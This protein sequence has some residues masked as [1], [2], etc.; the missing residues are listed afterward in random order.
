MVPP[1]PPF[2]SDQKRHRGGDEEREGERKMREVMV[3]VEGSG[4]C[5][6]VGQ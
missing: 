3:T 5:R 6:R 1:L 2:G 4:W